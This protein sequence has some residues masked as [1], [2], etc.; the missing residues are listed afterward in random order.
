MQRRKQHLM[1]LIAGLILPISAGAAS[2]VF[3]SGTN[4]TDVCKHVPSGLVKLHKKPIKFGFF[5]CSR[6]NGLRKAA[7]WLTAL[8]RNLHEDL[9]GT[10]RDLLSSLG[11]SWADTPPWYLTSTS[12]LVDVVRRFNSKRM[13]F[14]DFIAGGGWKGADVVRLYTNIPHDSLTRALGWVLDKV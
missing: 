4:L 11:V 6:K 2:Y 10:W 13:S 7:R 12:Q 14:R 1:S 3:D 9:S 5:A 8:L